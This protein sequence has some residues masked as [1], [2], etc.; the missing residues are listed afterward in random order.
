MKTQTA[1]DI[2]QAIETISKALD[3]PLKDVA[4]RIIFLDK[5]KRNILLEAQK[6]WIEFYDAGIVERGAMLGIK[7]TESVNDKNEKCYESI[8]VLSVRNG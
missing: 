5:N 2:I 4:E 6:K 7:I 8:K 3:I 1:L